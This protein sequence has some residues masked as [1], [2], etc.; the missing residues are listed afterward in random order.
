M[1]MVPSSSAD[2]VAPDAGDHVDDAARGRG[3]IRRIGPLGYFTSP[4]AAVSG[5]D[6]AAKVV[7]PSLMA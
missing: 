5:M 7:R 2:L 3:T 6:V 4:K 1:T